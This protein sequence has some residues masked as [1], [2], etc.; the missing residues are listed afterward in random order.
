MYKAFTKWQQW[1][2]E[3]HNHKKHEKINWKKCINKQ[4]KKHYSKKQE[5][6]WLLQKSEH[7]IKKEKYHWYINSQNSEKAR[8]CFQSQC[9]NT[10]II[11]ICLEKYQIMIRKARAEFTSEIQEFKKFKKLM[12]KKLLDVIAYVISWTKNFQ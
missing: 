7:H 4:Y 5:T 6:W 12:T 10:K 1:V 11:E 3:N 8:M 2:R 9:M